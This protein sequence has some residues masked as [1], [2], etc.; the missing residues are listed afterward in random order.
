M[1][2]SPQ[3]W[4]EGDMDMAYPSRPVLVGSCILF[5]QGF[6]VLLA[7]CPSRR[8]DFRII[9]MALAFNLNQYDCSR[10]REWLWT[11]SWHVF[12][13]IAARMLPDSGQR[14]SPAPQLWMWRRRSQGFRTRDEED[15]GG[16]NINAGEEVLRI[17]SSIIAR[18]H[19]PGLISKE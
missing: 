13:R 9:G 5:W 16:G 15:S 11:N 6:L 7:S 17:T 10:S 19:Q 14:V 2:Q 12:T 1:G 8:F 3:G 18:T 4:V